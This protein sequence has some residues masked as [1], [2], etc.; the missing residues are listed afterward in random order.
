VSRAFYDYNGERLGTYT[1]GKNIADLITL[2]REHISQA[3]SV[4]AA[5]I[6]LGAIETFFH[7]MWVVAEDRDWVQS[8]PFLA[9]FSI[10]I[11]KLAE[12]ANDIQRVLMTH[13]MVDHGLDCFAPRSSPNSLAN[14]HE[15]HG[16]NNWLVFTGKETENFEHWIVLPKEMILN[17]LIQYLLPLN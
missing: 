16:A 12:G 5:D 10:V 6:H 9:T 1:I 14:C 8:F 4:L 17:E 15:Q 2:D 13:V 11:S 7:M 3:C